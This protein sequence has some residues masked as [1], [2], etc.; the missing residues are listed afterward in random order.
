MIAIFFVRL[1]HSI[2]SVFIYFCVFLNRKT[3]A[4]TIP[5]GNLRKL[6]TFT[7]TVHSRE[8]VLRKIR[9]FILQLPFEN[10]KIFLSLRFIKIRNF[11]EMRFKSLEFYKIRDSYFLFSNVLVDSFFFFTNLLHRS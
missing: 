9:S 10:T 7:T 3:N 6:I 11:R 1:A 4:Y 8:T 2:R 5:I